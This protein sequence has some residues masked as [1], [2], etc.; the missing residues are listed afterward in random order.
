MKVHFKERIS[1]V[2]ELGETDTEVELSEEE[3][4]ELGEQIY[5]TFDKVR[6]LIFHSNKSTHSVY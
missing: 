6:A 2:T 4:Q 3:L 5:G 1:K